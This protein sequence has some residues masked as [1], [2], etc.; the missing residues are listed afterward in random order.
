M[1]DNVA[2]ATKLQTPRTIWGQSFDGTANITGSLT[3]VTDITGTGTFTGAN[4]KATDSVYVNGIRLHKTV[5]GAVTIE[6]NLLVTGG[7]TAYST[8]EEGGS[9]GGGIDVDVLWEILGGT[10][11]QQINK[12]HLTDALEGYLTRA[13]SDN[14]YLLK[15]IY[16]AQDILNKLKTV[17][18][19][20]SGLDADTVDGYQI[21]QLF[22]N[23][24]DVIRL[25]DIDNFKNRESGT[26]SVLDTGASGLLTVFRCNRSTS[27][28]EIFT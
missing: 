16:T 2:S 12:S 3:S 1:V 19:A 7:I 13:E 20:N 4:I 24:R 18:G 28:L 26:Y 14:K 27:A 22:V 15:S 10:G 17:D 21:S 6:G 25:T 11:T 8:G 5:D 9:S 23:N